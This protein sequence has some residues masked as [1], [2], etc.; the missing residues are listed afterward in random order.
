MVE[1]VESCQEATD[2]ALDECVPGTFVNEEVGE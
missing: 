1:E 2:R